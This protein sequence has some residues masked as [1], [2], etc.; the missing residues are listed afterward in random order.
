MSQASR[1]SRGQC[2]SKTKPSRD[3][4]P[5][6]ILYPGPSRSP[7]LSTSPKARLRRGTPACL[8]RN[9]VCKTSDCCR[10]GSNMKIQDGRVRL[11]K[12]YKTHLWSGYFSSLPAP[13]RAS[14]S[15]LPYPVVAGVVRHLLV[16]WCF[17]EEICRA[18]VCT[19]TFSSGGRRGVIFRV[20]REELDEWCGGFWKVY[21]F[22][23]RGGF[24]GG[25]VVLFRCLFDLEKKYLNN[26]KGS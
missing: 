2:G 26:G 13:G 5:K 8:D 22:C 14:R 6:P 18:S 19:A 20:E 1:C 12:D 17:P 11:C 21:M 4:D 16:G 24:G 9:T 3:P 10:T 15:D 25:V 23:G 7:P